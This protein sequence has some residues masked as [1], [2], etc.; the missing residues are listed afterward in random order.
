MSDIPLARRDA[1]AARLMRGQP[2]VSTTLALEFGV[3]EDAIRRDLRALAADG[4][5][6]RVYGGA[7]PVSP[8]ST[9]MATRVDEARERKEALARVAATLVESGE[10]VFLDNGSTNLALVKFLPADY[11]LTVATNSIAIAA[12]VVKRKDMQLIMLG[13]LVD[14]HVGGCV[15]ANAMARLAE[16]NIDTCFIGACAVSVATGV[17]A[18]NVAD[19]MFKRALR[20]AGQRTVIMTTTEKLGTRAPHRIAAVGEIGKLVLE[21]DAPAD[22]VDALVQAGASILQAAPLS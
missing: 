11:R 6:R 21:S 17:S 13:G 9:P 3:S 16:M 4:L 8:A 5:C 15:D 19:A 12:E 1:I 18:F 2:A 10:L 22:A 14:P 20:D 7:L